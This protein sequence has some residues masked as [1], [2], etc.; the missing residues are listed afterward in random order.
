MLKQAME[1]RAVL[2]I[3]EVEKEADLQILYKDV[4]GAGLIEELLSYRLVLAVA[5]PER[6]FRLPPA[7]RL[8]HVLRR[9]AV[10]LAKES[11]IEHLRSF[12]VTR[13]NLWPAISIIIHRPTF[14]TTVNN[15]YY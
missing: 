2:V 3:I 7:L 5:G 1:M 15:F 4:V 6:T 14:I 13:P 10:A 12:V 11:E 8:A 9:A